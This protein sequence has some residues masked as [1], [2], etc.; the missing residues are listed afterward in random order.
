MKTLELKVYIT[1]EGKYTAEPV[2]KMRPNPNVS[3]RDYVR[4][5]NPN[6]VNLSSNELRHKAWRAGRTQG[7]ANWVAKN[8]HIVTS[9]VAGIAYIEYDGRMK[10][11]MIKNAIIR[12]LNNKK[13]SI[14]VEP[15]SNARKPAIEH[16]IYV[17]EFTFKNVD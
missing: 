5:T 8:S 17:K 1:S 13:S 7:Y 3:T 11:W 14:E 15:L 6:S 12:A 16:T 9:K 10:E 4:A 2:N